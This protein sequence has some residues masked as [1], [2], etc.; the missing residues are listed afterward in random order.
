MKIEFND[1]KVYIEIDCSGAIC[2]AFA[3]YG[4]YEDG[5]CEELTDKEL[6]RIN[7]YHRK[8][9]E[10]YCLEQIGYWRE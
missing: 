7:D 1:R 3:T 10:E 9:I 8:A 6:D 5:E 2:D 4:Y